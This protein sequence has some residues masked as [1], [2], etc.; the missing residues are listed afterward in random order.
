MKCAHYFAYVAFE[1]RRTAIG[2]QYSDFDKYK[3]SGAPTPLA[4]RPIITK[5]SDERLT[6]CWKP[7]VST[8]PR[9]PVTYQVELLELPEGLSC[10]PPSH[11]P[12][13]Y[14]PNKIVISFFFIVCFLINRKATGLHTERAFGVVHAR[15]AILF[16]SR[17]I[18]SAFVSIINMAF[19]IPAHTC[20]RIA[21]N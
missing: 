2:D 7:S 14:M 20:K 16:P 12:A 18:D 13:M 6:L 10:C 5:M 4:D 19:L 3:K 1:T 8:A 21:T 15:Y 9:A 11:I 17:T